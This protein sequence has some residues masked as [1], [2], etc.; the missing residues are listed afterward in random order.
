MP[1]NLVLKY[2]GIYFQ[3]RLVQLVLDTSHSA[4]FSS[5]HV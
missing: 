5:V 2:G 1:D 3:R 4:I